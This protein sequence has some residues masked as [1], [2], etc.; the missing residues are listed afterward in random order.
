[1][2]NFISGTNS[3]LSK[4]SKNVS[5]EELLRHRTIVHKNLYESVGQYPN[6]GIGFKI[7]RNNWP[8]D[9]FYVLSDIQFKVICNL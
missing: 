2:K 9:C 5:L 4:Y 8:I 7:W 1:M 6:N 3:L